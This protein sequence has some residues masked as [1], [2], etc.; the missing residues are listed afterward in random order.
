MTAIQDFSAKVDAAFDKIGV[1]VDGIAADI[2]FLK[3]KI[4]ELQSNPGPISP[5]DQ[6]LLDALEAKVNGMVAKVEALDAQT[7][8]APT[9]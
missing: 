1:S 5:E 4:A 9:P 8:S 3:D 7:D 2:Q 6:A